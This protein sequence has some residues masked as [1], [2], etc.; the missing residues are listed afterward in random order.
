LATINGVKEIDGTISLKVKIFEIEKQINIFIVDKENFNYDFL[1][2]LDCIREF[3]LKQ[4]ENLQITQI[5][6][7]RFRDE[8]KNKMNLENSQNNLGR[9]EILYKNIEGYQ[10]NYNKHIDISKGGRSIRPVF[11]P[12]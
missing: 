3:K 6:Q 4:D 8:E 12:N 7:S 1:I 2:G 5:I 11:D 9:E 10:I